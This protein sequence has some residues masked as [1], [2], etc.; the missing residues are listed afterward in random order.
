[1]MK[2]KIGQ[3]HS[4]HQQQLEADSL[5][6]REETYNREQAKLADQ[7]HVPGSFFQEDTRACGMCGTQNLIDAWQCKDCFAFTT[8]PESVTPEMWDH[9]REKYAAEMVKVLFPTNVVS[10]DV[11]RGVP[12]TH[13]ISN[14]RRKA[15]KSFNAA[16]SVSREGVPNDQAAKR[17][18]K[19]GL[20]TNYPGF[21]SGAY[22]T[23]LERF[24]H[25]TV[26][27]TTCA[28]KGWTIATARALDAL[29]VSAGDMKGGK[30]KEERK[31]L[32]GGLHKRGPAVPAGGNATV[33]VKNTIYEQQWRAQHQAG[34]KAA[35]ARVLPDRDQAFSALVAKMPQ[36]P[37]R[38]R[39]AVAAGSP[40]PNA[41]TGKGSGAAASSGDGWQGWNQGNSSSA[42]WNR[43][44]QFHPTPWSHGAANYNNTSYPTAGGDSV[45]VS[46]SGKNKGQKGS[47]KGQ[48]R[49]GRARRHDRW[50][51]QPSWS[52]APPWSDYSN[53]I[54]ADFANEWRS[55]K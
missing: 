26:Y 10:E 15:R 14:D 40:S 29:A 27:N 30:S 2:K 18:R 53:E 50:E 9:H 51:Q 47:Q 31:C 5:A 55:W 17:L 1:M 6:A 28:E 34:Y 20:P 8:R 21:Q 38:A 39:A 43:D 54:G 32:Y 16:Q 42:S 13:G 36:A 24:L 7:I 19:G 35:P 49:T 44:P 4:Q 37:D 3:K 48:E 46:A 41:E 23:I 22:P 45:P 11:S 25:D 33:A 12:A 52:N